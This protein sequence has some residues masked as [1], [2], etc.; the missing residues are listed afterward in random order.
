M[1]RAY[2]LCCKHFSYPYWYS[3]IQYL[4]VL[5]HCCGINSE[6]LKDFVIAMHFWQKN[7]MDRHS[8]SSQLWWF[9]FLVIE[10]Y[11]FT[12]PSFWSPPLVNHCYEPKHTALSNHT[13]WHL[14]RGHRK[15]TQN[16]PI[17]LIHSHSLTNVSLKFLW[18]VVNINPF[19]QT[20]GFFKIQF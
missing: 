12:Y 6:G 2:H 18:F 17:W 20:Q 10:N 3:S 4:T 7:K 13:A 16:S 8:S 19:L 15:Q 11:P 5:L 14:I 9:K 1:W